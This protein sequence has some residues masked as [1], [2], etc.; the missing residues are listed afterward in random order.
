MAVPH[1]IVKSMAT[2]GSDVGYTC[3]ILYRRSCRNQPAESKTES[4]SEPIKA[5]V[6]KNLIFPVLGCLIVY[7]IRPPE[8][9][10][11]FIVL[12]SSMPSAVMIALIIPKDEAKQKMVAA[13]I[14]LSS[15][16][17]ILA[18]PVFM[19]IYGWLYW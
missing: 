14:V 5:T 13:S 7:V 2:I 18:I 19:G 4:W 9:I 15:L 3:H 11:L 6:F 8:Y 16:V 12:Q 10:A 17:S 1:S